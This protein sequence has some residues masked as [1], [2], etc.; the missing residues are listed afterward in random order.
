[1]IIKKIFGFNSYRLVK[2]I[3]IQGE[4]Y[5]AICH[6]DIDTKSTVEKK[7]DVLSDLDL[8]LRTYIIECRDQP[9]FTIS[10]YRHEYRA[11]IHRSNPYIVLIR[12]DITDDILLSLGATSARDN[13]VDRV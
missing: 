1:M 13:G 6:G 8:F 5:I 3:P 2:D 4:R 7:H 9:F 10:W 11:F 12:G